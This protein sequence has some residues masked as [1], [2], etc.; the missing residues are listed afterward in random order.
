LALNPSSA[1]ALNLKGILAYQ[2]KDKKSAVAYFNKALES[3]PGFGET[4]TNL[5]TIQWEEGQERQALENYERGFILDPTDFDV[6]TIY[7]SA[8]TALGEFQRAQGFVQA[9]LGLHPH[10]K[11]IRYMLID[12]LIQQSNCNEA[13]NAIGEAVAKFGIQDGILDAALKIR[14]QL[15]IIQIKK[16][17]IET[18]GFLMHDR[19][20]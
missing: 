13:I 3:D 16:A 17:L 18:K 12:I 5:G 1:P 19:E 11:K 4:Y 14:D 20:K 15:G 2:Q 10:N 9:A 8:V 7:H 6:A